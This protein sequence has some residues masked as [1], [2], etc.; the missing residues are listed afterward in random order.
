MRISN[1]P[2][3]DGWFPALPVVAFVA[4]G[5]WGVLAVPSFGQEPPRDRIIIE[6]EPEE[7]TSVVPVW[8]F[9][10]YCSGFTTHR[11]V[12]NSG[13]VI[14]GTDD[15]LRS[16]V[17][18]FSQGDILYLR[19]RRRNSFKEGELY[20]VIRRGMGRSRSW[21]PG[22]SWDVRALGKMH[23][24][25]ARIRV[26]KIFRRT[27]AAEILTNCEPIEIGDQVIP[28]ATR[29]RPPVR[30]T[31][32]T[33]TFSPSTEKLT[34][35]ITLFQNQRGSAAQG[36]IVYINVGR[37]SAVGPGDIFTIFVVKGQSGLRR[38]R[39]TRYP[40]ENIGQLLI[41]NAQERSSTALITYSTREVYPGALI[42]LVN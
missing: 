41:L 27:V 18:Q 28:F 17:R 10:T 34:G 23:R 22:Q 36:S 29:T 24:D 25:I 38:Y 19:P 32:A 21:Y 42:E 6:S 31:R 26:I 15:D 8:D 14:G 7:D 37:R 13:R 16:L 2:R 33:E 12:R 1:L 11:G 20:H 3:L 4:L 39:S 35:R 40:R 5:T 9:E 30:F